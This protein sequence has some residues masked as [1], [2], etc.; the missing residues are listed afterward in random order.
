M[1]R[2]K[3]RINNKTKIRKNLFGYGKIGEE[4]VNVGT[5][6]KFAKYANGSLWP[7]YL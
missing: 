2:Q 6:Q 5:T 4:R 1:Q 3:I 7:V